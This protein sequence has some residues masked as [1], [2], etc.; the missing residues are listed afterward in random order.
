MNIEVYIWARQFVINTEQHQ[1]WA[2]HVNVFLSVL[3]VKPVSLVM[4]DVQ[5]A[6]YNGPHLL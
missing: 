1:R 6:T 3:T 4:Y 2:Y 5:G